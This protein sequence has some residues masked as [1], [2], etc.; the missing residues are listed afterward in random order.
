MK[1][2]AVSTHYNVGMFSLVLTD[3]FCRHVNLLLDCV[4]FS[5]IIQSNRLLRGSAFASHYRT[6]P[7]HGHYSV[8]CIKQ[9]VNYSLNK[10]R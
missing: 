6:E 9:G 10:A 2:S 4:R 5:R 7:S 3:T 8:N 1:F